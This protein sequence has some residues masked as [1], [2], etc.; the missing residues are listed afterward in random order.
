MDEK[1][2]VCIGKKTAQKL[3]EF[4]FEANYVCMKREHTNVKSFIW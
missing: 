2:F 4:G 3:K 1:F